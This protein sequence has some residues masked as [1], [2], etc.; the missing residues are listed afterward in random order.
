MLEHSLGVLPVDLVVAVGHQV[1]D[2]DLLVVA[3]LPVRQGVDARRVAVEDD[4]ALALGHGRDDHPDT[5]RRFGPGFG[6][7]QRNGIDDLDLQTAVILAN[8]LGEGVFGQNF[9]VVDAHARK[10][11][12]D[13]ALTHQLVGLASVVELHHSLD[14]FALQFV[15]ERLALSRDRTRDQSR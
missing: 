1:A 2:L 4:V 8:G 14:D 12:D 6:D 13:E 5:R 9:D 7:E 3:D 11:T 10:R 15:V